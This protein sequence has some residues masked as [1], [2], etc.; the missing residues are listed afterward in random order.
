MEKLS[1]REKIVMWCL[2]Y[3]IR[4]MTP[5]DKM[6]DDMKKMIEKVQHEVYCNL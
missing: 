5:N 1:S 2:L 4:L 6:T 3:V